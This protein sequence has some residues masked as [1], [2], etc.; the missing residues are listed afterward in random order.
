MK[1]FRNLLLSALLILP[2]ATGCVQDVKPEPD[3]EPLLTDFYFADNTVSKSYSFLEYERI[4]Y[5]EMKKEYSDVTIDIPA[6]YK[7]CIEVKP[8]IE[9]HNSYRIHLLENKGDKERVIEVKFKMK[10]A[11]H[12]LTMKINQVGD[13]MKGSMRHALIALYNATCELGWYH[14][15]NWCSNKPISQWYGISLASDT[16]NLA[17]VGPVCYGEEDLWNISLFCNNMKGIIPDE[18]WKICDKFRSIDLNGNM[19]LSKAIQLGELYLK[20]SKA[21]DTIWHKKLVKLDLGFTGIA[22]TLDSK[23]AKSPNLTELNLSRCE[24]NGAI[25]KE[26]L[27][28]EKLRILELQDASL[29]GDIPENIGDLKNLEVLNLCDNLDFGGVFPKSI[30]ELTELNTLNLGAT[31][32]SGTLSPKIKNL[33]NLEILYVYKNQMEG[34]IP[35]EIGLLTKLFGFYGEIGFAGS[36]F[37]NIPEFNRFV[38][39][40]NGD[41]DSWGYFNNHHQLK[42]GKYITQEMI[43]DFYVN[44]R[45]SYITLPM[46]KWYKERY[47]VLCWEV[48]ITYRS[49]DMDGNYDPKYPYADD[50]QYPADQY[51][52][53]E[54]LGAWTHPSYNG[55]AAKHYHI[56]N[57]EWTYDENF[58]WNDPA[59][60]EEWHI[61]DWQSIS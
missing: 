59:E 43:Y 19:D 21:P 9:Y 25:P 55:K 17:G 23:V 6:E 49:G 22:I 50:L 13:N 41:W 47:K 45:D 38:H 60:V 57:G 5:V 16:I 14:K 40:V 36:H 27:K 26:L 51:F 28:L 18:F 31:K 34:E 1:T 7:S 37:T 15:D 53:D 44:H 42:K 2:M 39:S 30:Y 29:H 10:G 20:G 11:D 32:I 61:G 56:V 58:D 4:F 3:P 54:K 8:S 12:D 24:V 52:F 33:K 48:G 35:E 46:P